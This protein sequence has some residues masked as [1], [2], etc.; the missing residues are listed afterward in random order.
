MK[1]PLLILLLACGLAMADDCAT[2]TLTREIYQDNL[3]LSW[4]VTDDCFWW[5]MQES[6]D[7]VQWRTYTGQLTYNCPNGDTN[8]CYWYAV[9]TNAAYSHRLLPID[10]SVPAECQERPTLTVVGGRIQWGPTHCQLWMPEVSEDL[11]AWIPFDGRRREIC[12]YVNGQ[13]VNC[14][15]SIAATNRTQFYRLKL[16]PGL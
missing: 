7:G 13:Q 16:A 9:T 10:G 6:A 1:T 2:P 15:W 5:Y 11:L 12:D 8:A 4:R 14:I 3:V